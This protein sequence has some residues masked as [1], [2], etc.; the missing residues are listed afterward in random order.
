[1]AGVEILGI[2]ASVI[3]IAD[4]G[5]RLSVKLYTFTRKV[6]GAGRSIQ[7]IA[8][9]IAATGAALRE[10]GEALE[11]DK[12]ADLA[13]R[14][15]IES[16]RQM[17]SDCWKVFSDINESIG[18]DSLFKASKTDV[19]KKPFDLGSV[20]LPSFTFKQRLKY[21]FIEP[22]IDLLKTKLESL[23]SSLVLM[24]QVLSLAEQIRK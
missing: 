19:S 7:E 17:V 3:Q 8:Q 11:E 15:S 20:R 10:L 22:Q 18:G 5:A 4:V 6:K 16:T 14:Q 13:S 21:P 9:E 2:A 12:Y 23:K 24:L 1:M